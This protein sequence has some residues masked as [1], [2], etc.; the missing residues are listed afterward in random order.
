MQSKKE[1]LHHQL[2]NKAVDKGTAYL[3]LSYIRQIYV[4]DVYC[5]VI[6]ADM[7]VY[8]PG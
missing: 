7:W 6:E 3:T 1:N 2:E 8:L 5:K 4:Y